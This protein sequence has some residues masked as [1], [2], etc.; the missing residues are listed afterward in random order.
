[1]SHLIGL[2]KRSSRG[3]ECQEAEGKV[4]GGRAPRC[5]RCRRRRCEVQAVPKRS[6]RLMAL[7]FLTVTGA[8][9]TIALGATSATADPAMTATTLAPA[10]GGTA[11]SLTGMV[12]PGP[13][14][15]TGVG[16]QSLTGTGIGQAVIATETNGMWAVTPAPLPTDADQSSPAG[17]ALDSI[18]CPAIGIRVAVG[19]Y[20][21][22]GDDALPLHTELAGTWSGASMPASAMPVLAYL[23]STAPPITGGYLFGGTLAVGDD[24]LLELGEAA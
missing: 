1:M 22:T 7:P 18:A 4:G 17:S 3:W 19:F 23:S 14:S 2:G 10:P 12:C 21:T 15:C 16:D 11:P 6:I 24:V 20:A 8:A 9:T 5:P 13:S